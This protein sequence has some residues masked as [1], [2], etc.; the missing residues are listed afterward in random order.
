MNRPFL[1]ISYGTDFIPT[2]HAPRTN[3][4]RER[5]LQ[6]YRPARNPAY[7]NPPMVSQ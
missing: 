7:I 3:V 2:P 5:N 6:Q 4:I 1:S